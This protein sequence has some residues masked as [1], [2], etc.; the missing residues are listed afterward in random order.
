MALLAR[1]GSKGYRPTQYLCLDFSRVLLRI[2]KERLI[3]AIPNCLVKTRTWD[4]EKA[5]TRAIRD[6]RPGR[7]PSL[8]LLLG[9]TLGNPYSPLSV[10]RNLALSG[11]PGGLLL[12]NVA[13]AGSK[14]P[15]EELA[16]YRNRTFT[17]AATQPLISA[18]VRP[19]AGE[20]SLRFQPNPPAVVDDFI[21]RK[22]VR[23]TFKGQSITL[24][25][26]ESNRCFYSRRFAPPELQCMLHSS[27]W[28][29]LL[30]LGDASRA[31]AVM[32]ARLDCQQVDDSGSSWRV[33]V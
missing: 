19:S 24:L 3:D 20:F 32:I 18:G 23:L 21:L 6:W 27:G 9:Q 31:H 16:V 13:L 14:S 17:R 8:F 2:A 33:P 4:F 25:P 30:T 15:E 7:G 26:R 1:L 11:C 29:L 12:L 10:L 5:P 22:R 28:K